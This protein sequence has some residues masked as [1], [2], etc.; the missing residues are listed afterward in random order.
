MTYPQ[1]TAEGGK[2]T[3]WFSALFAAKL[4]QRC[5]SDVGYEYVLNVLDPFYKV[6]I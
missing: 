1:K 3:D 6:Y 2:A 4:L 5:L